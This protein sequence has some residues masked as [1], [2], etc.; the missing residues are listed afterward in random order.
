MPF[1]HLDPDPTKN[2]T[3]YLVKRKRE[4]WRIG[5]RVDTGDVFESAEQFPTKE[6]ASAKA[7][8]WCKERG[9]F[10]ERVH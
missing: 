10:R 4:G 9:I 7:D 6:A 3:M 1:N 2:G 8:A 5:I